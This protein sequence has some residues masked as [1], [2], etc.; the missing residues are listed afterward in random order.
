M[1]DKVVCVDPDKI[2]VIWPQ[3]AHFIH[4]AF[5]T[6]LGDDTAETIKAD[7]D[8]KRALLWVVWD[9]KGLIAVATTTLV[10][11]PNGNKLCIVTS[12]AGRELPRWLH[13]I[14]ELEKYAKDE[15]CQKLRLTG[16]AGWKE[17]LKDRGYRQPWMCLEKELH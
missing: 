2:D 11:V 8:A 4:A 13:F 15:G 3:A 10:V 16:R 9:G 17:W 6:G 1:T 5:L 12:C 7:L 14:G